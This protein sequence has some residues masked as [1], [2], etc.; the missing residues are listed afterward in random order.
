MITQFFKRLGEIRGT[1]RVAIFLVLLVGI[2]ANAM[3]S[4]IT[5]YNSDGEATAYID[6]DDEMTIYLWDGKPVAYL[7]GKSIYGF[8]GEHLGWFEHG[9]IWDHD[10]NCVGFIRGAVSILT[11]LEPL[12]GLQELQPLRSLE[13]LEPLE[14]LHSRLWSDMPLEIFLAEGQE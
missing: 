14:P 6:T 10:G 13:E 2:T 4:E 9:V 12:K 5:L 11:R 7:D 1:T 3:A 8:N